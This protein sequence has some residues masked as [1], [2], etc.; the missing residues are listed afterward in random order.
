M[1]R[2]LIIVWLLTGCGA[3]DKIPGDV[4]KPEQMQAVLWDMIRA[5]AFIPELMK[6]DSTLKGPA[7]NV[8][9]YYQVFSAHKVSKEKFLS[10]FAWYERNPDQFRT[11]LDTMNARQQRLQIRSYTL[12]KKSTGLAD[13]TTGIR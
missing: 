8:E 7:K 9:L 11:L 13:T 2:Y 10:S 4:L 5:D 12:P 1:K 3:K 6:K